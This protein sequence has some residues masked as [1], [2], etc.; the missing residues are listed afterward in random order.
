MKQ[1]TRI[2]S[3]LMA[4]MLSAGLLTSCTQT[5]PVSTGSSDQ[6]TE[7]T[8][9]GTAPQVEPMDLTG[10][11][12]VFEATAGISGDTVVGAVGEYEV[13][14]G[15]L[16]Y[17]LN[18]NVEYML[19]Q[20]QMFG[21]SEL[22]WDSVVE[23]GTTIEQ[24]L[25]ES[26]M[27]L[28]AYYRL[29]PVKA[30]E[31]GLTVSE[32]IQTELDAYMTEANAELGS[33]EMLR[34]YLWMSLLTE[35][36]FRAIYE[37]GSLK[38]QL[39]EACYGPGSEDY[40]TDAE[41]LTYAEEELG[42]Y[43]AKHILLLTKNMEEP[44]TNEDGTFGGYAPL[45]DPVVAEKEAK[46]AQ[47]LTQLRQ[48]EDPVALFDTLMQEHSE[49]SG[50]IANP[51]GYT[52]Y[53]GEMVPEFETTALELENGEISDVVESTYGYHIILRLPLDPEDFRAGLIQARMG[54]RSQQ[55]LDEYGITT[56]EVYQQIDPSS[57]REK[58]VALQTAVTEELEPI[59]N[60]E[61]ESES[62]EAPQ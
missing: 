18:Y 14:A 59:L 54:E 6:N 34:H 1:R 9:E 11:T 36:T 29:I 40:P 33:E 48:A 55:W 58:V 30:E 35:D 43:R 5:E 16:L 46:A 60:P 2:I 39:E 53:K 28:A 57:F 20:Y 47:L 51:D 42:Y 56:N 49:D 8:V 62:T 45:E 32:G 41:V 23:D 17:W 38:L 50:L 37:N 26:S 24:N 7:T 44:I 61:L 25:L 19:E 21:I 22:P 4:G 13:T 52:T 27:N 15:S 31:Y 10:V 3:L 12:D